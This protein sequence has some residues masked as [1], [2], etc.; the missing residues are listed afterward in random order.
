MEDQFPRNKGYFQGLSMSI[1]YNLRDGMGFIWFYIFKGSFSI[2][3]GGFN[4]S[5]KYELVSLNNQI[6]NTVYGKNNPNAPNHQPDK[7]PF[8][9]MSMVSHRSHSFPMIFPACDVSLVYLP[10]STEV[11]LRIF[12]RRSSS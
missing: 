2:L 11:Q 6:P 7:A 1:S 4:I 5:E 9:R 12:R 8:M 10:I 3:V